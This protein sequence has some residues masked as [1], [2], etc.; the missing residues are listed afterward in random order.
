M[1][2]KHVKDHLC[3]FERLGKQ[4]IFGNPNLSMEPPPKNELHQLY[5]ISL[6]GLFRD[7]GLPMTGS[8][9]TRLQPTLNPE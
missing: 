7:P 1:H 5:P 6:L 3:I 4:V 8:P 2:E 9:L